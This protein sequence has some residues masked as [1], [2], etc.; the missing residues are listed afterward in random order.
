MEILNFPRVH[1]GYQDREGRSV[2]AGCRS[3]YVV[4]PEQLKQ[5]QEITDDMYEAL[6]EMDRM[7]KENDTVE[8]I[9]LF[10]KGITRRVLARAEGK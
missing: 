9:A 2:C 7:V 5:A 6:K 8:N 1:T 3:Y 10:V 4:Q